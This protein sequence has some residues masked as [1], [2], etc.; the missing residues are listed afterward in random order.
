[1]RINNVFKLSVN[2]AKYTFNASILTVII[3]HF[4]ELIGGWFGKNALTLMHY[5][6]DID[7]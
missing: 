3:C 6:L 7:T 2:F 4:C 1:M 5:L